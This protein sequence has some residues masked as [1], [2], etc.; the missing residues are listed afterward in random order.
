MSCAMLACV[1]GGWGTNSLSCS[2]I[3]PNHAEKSNESRNT[4]GIVHVGGSDRLRGR[5]EQNDTDEADPSHG[6][7]IDGLAPPAHAERTW[8][9]L[10]SSLVPAMRDD[11]SNVA[12]VECRC[13]DIEDGNDSQG[14]A[15]TDEVEAATERYDEPYS[16]DWSIRNR[17]DFAPESALVSSTS[18]RRIV[19]ILTQRT[20]RL[21]REQK[22]R[23]FWRWPTMQS[24]R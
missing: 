10:D 5:E 4:D 19:M 21:R 2:S 16:I 23:P 15:N 1:T 13:G 9:K 24:N 3:P 6:D 18:M 11:D 22:P 20:G 8:M 7:R 14:A 17:I 12:D